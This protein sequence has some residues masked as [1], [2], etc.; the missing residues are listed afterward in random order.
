MKVDVYD[1]YVHTYDGHRLHFD[2][3][4]PAGCGARC[5]EKA[6]DY[7]RAWLRSIGMNPERIQ[8]ELCRYCHSEAVS[9]EVST[10]LETQGYFILKMEGC[11]SQTP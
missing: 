9:P 11:P 2:V 8:L 7:A 5:N 4:L 10:Q 1:T 6:A 3:F